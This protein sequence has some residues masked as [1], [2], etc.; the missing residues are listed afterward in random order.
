MWQ[1][2]W[3]I[4]PDQVVWE[5]GMGVPLFAMSLAGYF[6]EVMATDVDLDLYTNVISYFETLSTAK[7]G[8][9]IKLKAT[10]CNGFYQK[11]SNTLDSKCRLVKRKATQNIS[12][13]NKRDPPTTS[14][15][16]KNDSSD[17]HAADCSD[18][19]TED[20]YIEEDDEV[21]DTTTSCS[22]EEGS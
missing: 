22:D 9:T 21:S 6:K 19:D 12:Y 7:K 20:E 2:N 1:H 3:L 5:I 8:I 11:P 15:E 17:D 18:E 14:M 13:V 10:H 4:N 16:D